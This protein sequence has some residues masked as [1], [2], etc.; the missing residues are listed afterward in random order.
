MY[1]VKASQKVSAAI[2]R[3]VHC[4]RAV[5][6]KMC[7][8]SYLFHECPRRSKLQ[9]SLLHL[10]LKSYFLSLHL[11]KETYDNSWYKTV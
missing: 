3:T 8:I 11:E 10:K 9:I 4:I 1:L 6:T 7:K 5:R 2:I